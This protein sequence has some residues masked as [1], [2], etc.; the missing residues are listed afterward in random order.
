MK[1]FII[2]LGL[3]TLVGCVSVGKDFLKA[4]LRLSR[5]V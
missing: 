4:T 2:G 1:K 5:K 3:I